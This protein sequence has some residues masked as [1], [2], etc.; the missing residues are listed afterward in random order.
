M[1]SSFL[2]ALTI[3]KYLSILFVLGYWCYVIVDDYSL[4]ARYWRESWL[5]YIGLWCVYCIIYYLA[6]G[7]YYWGIAIALILIYH[8]LIKRSIT[9]NIQL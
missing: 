7:L 8:K 9:K 6:F 4:W 1:K 2:K 5:M 3:F